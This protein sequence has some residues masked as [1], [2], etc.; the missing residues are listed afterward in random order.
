MHNTLEL[1]HVGREGAALASAAMAEVLVGFVDFV[2]FEIRLK[3]FAERV[4]RPHVFI[5]TNFRMDI[6][7]LLVRWAFAEQALHIEV[8][9]S[10]E[11][12]E[13]KPAAGA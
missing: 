9:I 10:E 2:D 12:F 11:G 13:K 7:A 3:E 1:L 4:F 5:H 6:C 8:L